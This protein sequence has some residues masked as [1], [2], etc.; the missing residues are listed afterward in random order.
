MPEWTEKD[1][2]ATQGTGN[3]RLGY[4]DRSRAELYNLARER[5]IGGRSRMNKEE[6]VQALRGKR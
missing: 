2:P 1:E 4:E 6:L 5:G 3:P